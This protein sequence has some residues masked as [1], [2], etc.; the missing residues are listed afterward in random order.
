MCRIP[1][2][3]LDSGTLTE[4]GKKSLGRCSECKSRAGVSGTLWI[5]DGIVG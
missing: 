5:A 4:A 1:F 3:E 2:A